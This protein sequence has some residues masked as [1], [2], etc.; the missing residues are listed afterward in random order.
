[1]AATRSAAEQVVA[2]DRDVH[3]AL[4]SLGPY[5]LE[6]GD[7]DIKNATGV[8]QLISM[9]P[10]CF[11]SLQDPADPRKLRKKSDMTPAHE[12]LLEKVL[13]LTVR[14]DAI[15]LLE[16]IQTGSDMVETLY[17]R[18]A[19]QT[20]PDLTHRLN[21]LSFN[22]HV[23]SI[24]FVA[25]F[26]RI[27]DAFKLS[28]NPLTDDQQVVY[29]L[30]ALEPDRAPE[31]LHPFYTQ[32]LTS[33]PQPRCSE[34]IRKL[35]HICNVLKYNVAYKDAQQD[36]RAFPVDGMPSTAPPPVVSPK[37][38]TRCS[39]CNKSGHNTSHCYLGQHAPHYHTPGGPLGFKLIKEWAQRILEAE[40]TVVS[41]TMPATPVKPAVSHPR[42][43]RPPTTRTMSVTSALPP[44]TCTM[45]RT[46]AVRIEQKIKIK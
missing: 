8:Q 11:I 33:E 40:A 12:R 3:A 1:M 37:T 38:T 42:L 44:T 46:S 45:P 13:R 4:R 36:G 2:D 29:L 9:L 15:T 41:G 26:H 25:S 43:R 5:T 24:D 39:W 6:P 7:D 21:E 35:R 10:L 30:Q 28:G 34:I 18:Y 27:V 19:R 22:S 23:N 17:D 31:A 20:L 32:M 14:G 16:D